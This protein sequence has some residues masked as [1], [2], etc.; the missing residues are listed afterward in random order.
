MPYHVDVAIFGG[1]RIR[2]TLSVTVQRTKN[3]VCISIKHGWTKN[4]KILGKIPRQQRGE[5]K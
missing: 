1:N 3:K 5:H 2:N 4:A